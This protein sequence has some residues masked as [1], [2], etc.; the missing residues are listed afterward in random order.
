[1]RAVEAAREHAAQ[2]RAEAPAA[3]GGL[4]L[5]KRSRRVCAA[6]VAGGRS[7][8]GRR[9]EAGARLPGDHE[10]GEDVRRRLTSAL[11][12]PRFEAVTG[13]PCSTGQVAVCYCLGE[14]RPT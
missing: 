4:G 14:F 10:Q 11:V 6:R 1:M 8:A 12:P 13:R 3:P 5:L 2:Q 7:D 9:E